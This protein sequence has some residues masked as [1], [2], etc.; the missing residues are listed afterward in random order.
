MRAVANP[1]VVSD[2]LHLA[3]ATMMVAFPALMQSRGDLCVLRIISCHI[4][5][6]TCFMVRAS[7]PSS[8]AATR[9]LGLKILAWG[10]ELRLLYIPE[11]QGGSTSYW[12]EVINPLFVYLSL[13]ALHHFVPKDPAL[14]QNQYS[15]LSG[16]LTRFTSSNCFCSSVRSSSGTSETSEVSLTAGGS[17]TVPALP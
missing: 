14:Q 4:S 17:Q 16:V 15:G 5:L 2:C 1:R 10:G 12:A 3:H 13:T 11:F 9:T 7:S 6:L 8:H